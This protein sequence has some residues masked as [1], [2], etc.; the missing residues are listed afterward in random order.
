[1]HKPT[2]PRA[3]TLT[4]MWFTSK[5]DTELADDHQNTPENG[6]LITQPG[7]IRTACQLCLPWQKT[8][9]LNTHVRHIT[10]GPHAG[11]QRERSLPM[12]R[13]A[14]AT[15]HTGPARGAP[16]RQ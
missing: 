3:H 14:L 4:H 13:G 5:L 2:N 16:A 8:E 15:S 11:R 12:R 6:Q 1:M 7:I 9:H 10:R